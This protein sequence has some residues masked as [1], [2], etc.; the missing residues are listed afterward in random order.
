[1]LKNPD[2]WSDFKKINLNLKQ[3]ELLIENDAEF[4][5]IFRRS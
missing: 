4:I 3:P 2:V 5:G 1:M